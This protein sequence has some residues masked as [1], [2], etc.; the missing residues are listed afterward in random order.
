[1]MAALDAEP[2]HID[3]IALAAGIPIGTLLG[4]LLGLE[5]GGQAE[6][7][8]GSQFRRRAVRH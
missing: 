8:P 6:Q 5:L 2:R 1:V 4:V 7:L 3:E